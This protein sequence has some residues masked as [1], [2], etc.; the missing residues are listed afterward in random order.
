MS[1]ATFGGHE[2]RSAVCQGN[3]ACWFG[4]GELA[5]AAGEMG[6]GLVDGSDSTVQR[7]IVEHNAERVTVAPAEGVRNDVTRKKKKAV[8]R[9]LRF[10]EVPV[11]YGVGREQRR[12]DQ[13]ERSWMKTT[14]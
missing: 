13:M 1:W 14:S 11:K 2:L 6:K 3:R 8:M 7:S 10:G 9:R 12:F 4:G 5:H